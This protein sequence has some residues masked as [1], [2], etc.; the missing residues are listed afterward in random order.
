MNPSLY[1]VKRDGET[2][3]GGKEYNATERDMLQELDDVHVGCRIRPSWR[4]LFARE[5]LDQEEH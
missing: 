1:K 3:S 2:V 4:A 5:C